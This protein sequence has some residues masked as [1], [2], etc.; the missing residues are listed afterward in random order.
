MIGLSTYPGYDR[1]I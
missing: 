1:S